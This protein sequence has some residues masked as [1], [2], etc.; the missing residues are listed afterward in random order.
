MTLK[1]SP[2]CGVKILTSL[3]DGVLVGSCR[4]CEKPVVRLNPKTGK[5]EYLDNNSP[6]TTKKLR[7]VKSK[8]PKTA[9]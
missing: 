4:K 9:N 8:N 1:R 3:A 7:P 6:W 2:C 5:Q